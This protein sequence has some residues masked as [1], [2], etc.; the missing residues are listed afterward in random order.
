VR[1]IL[2]Y[3]DPGGETLVSADEHATLLAV[4]RA[5]KPDERIEDLIPV[6]EKTNGTSP[7]PRP[8][9]ATS[10]RSPRTIKPV[11]EKRKVLV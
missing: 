8:S 2:T 9:D 7:A 3:L 1:E 6:V 10:R 4:V 5:D 11:T